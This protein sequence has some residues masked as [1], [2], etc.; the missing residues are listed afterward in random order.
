MTE[1]KFTGNWIDRMVGYIAPQTAVKRAQARLAL[2]VLAHYDGASTGRRTENWKRVSGDANAVNGPALNILRDRARDLARNHPHAKRAVRTIRKSIVGYGIRPRP[3]AAGSRTLKKAVSMWDAWAN[4]TECDADGRHTIY[5]LQAMAAQSIAEAGEVLIR[6]RI[7]RTADGLTV[8]LQIQ[9]LEAD[10]LDTAKTQTLADGGY[11]IQGIEYDPIGRRRAYWL[12]P[13]HPGQTGGLTF[14]STASKPIPAS[15]IAHIFFSERPGQVRG[16]TWLAPVIVRLKDLDDYADAQLLRQKIAACF[17]AFV[18]DSAGGI[19]GL[20]E[21]KTDGSLVE[22]LEP[23][24]I[25]YLKPGQTVELVAPPTTSDYSPFTNAIL[26]AASV[27]VGLTYEQLTGDYSRVNYSSARMG[28]NEFSAELDDWRFNMFI[29]QF[30][31]PTW[32]W[33]TEAALIAG[34]L[35][36]RP[37]ADWTPPPLLMV[38]PEKEVRADLAAVRSGFKT[39]SEVIR[40]RGY[41]PDEHIAEIEADAKRLD[42]AGLVLD[43]DPRNTSAQGQI[44]ADPVDPAAPAD[45]SQGGANQ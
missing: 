22:T 36:E 26:C 42:D 17:T 4:T 39:L 12:F 8:P 29:P 33:F 24:M 15:E 34:S 3:R 18:S 10:Y 11:I 2:Q 14:T 1:K 6:K 40:E 23:G 37:R 35:T 41:D 9:V 25:N 38:D 45:P 43:S 13:Q 31:D 30:C 32:S 19:G 16:I 28:R 21:K 20:G 5:G 44:Q 27:G 7:R